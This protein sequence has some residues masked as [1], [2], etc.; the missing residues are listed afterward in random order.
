[1]KIQ[2]ITLSSQDDS[3]LNKKEP[4]VFSGLENKKINIFFMPNSA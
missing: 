1:M 3:F 2:S 4:I